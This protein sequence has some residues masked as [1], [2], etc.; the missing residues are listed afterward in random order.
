L[1]G[2]ILN[3]DGITKFGASTL[4]IN[5]DQSSL[6]RGNGYT[7]GWTVNEGGIVANVFGAFGDAVSTNTVTL[8]GSVAGAA[9]LTLN[10]NQGSALNEFYTMGNVLVTDNALI[11]HTPGAADRTQS[12]GTAGAFSNIIITSTGGALHDARFAYTSNQ[13]RSLLQ[14]GDVSAVGAN[15]SVILDVGQTAINN[16]LT[17][18]SGI[19]LSIAS[20]SGSADQTFKKWGNAELYIRGASTFAGTLSIEQGE[21][22]IFNVNSLG[23]G[24]VNVKRFGVLDI[25]AAGT[26]KTANYDIG[27]I[28]RWSVDGARTGSINLGSGTLQ[29]NNDQTGTVAVTMNG[30]SIEGFIKVDDQL[31]ATNGNQGA[32]YRILGA[33]VTF[34]LAGNSFLGQNITQGAN[35]FDNGAQANTYQPFGNAAAGAILEIKGVISGVG[36]LTKQGYDTVTL[37]GANTYSGGTNIVQGVLR[38]GRTNALPTSGNVTTTGNAVLDINGF[39]QTIRHLSSPVSTIAGS[40]G[41]VTNS[42]T[43]IKNLTVGNNSTAH[44]TYGGTIQ[45]NIAVVKTGGHVFR[46][47]APNTYVGGTNVNAGWLETANTTGSGTGTGTVSVNSGGTL[48]GGNAAGTT[49]MIGGLVVLNNGGSL[50]PGAVDTTGAPISQGGTL[51]VAALQ[52]NGGSITFQLAAP[53]NVNNDRIAVTG[54]D[55]G[56]SVLSITAPTS[57]L[58]Q[59][60]LPDTFNLGSYTLMTYNNGTRSGFSNLSLGTTTILNANGFFALS[61]IDDFANDRILLNAVASTATGLRWHQP[62][63]SDGIWDTGTHTPKNW[64]DPGA[65]AADWQQPGFD[66]IFD[67]TA[68]GT[69]PVVQG[70]VTPLSVQFMNS[71]KDYVISGTGN[72]AGSGTF[73]KTGSGKV[74]IN[75]GTNTFTGGST[76]NMGTVQFGASTTVVAGAIT[77]GPLGTGTIVLDPTGTLTLQADASDRTLANSV[78]VDGSGVV[79]FATNG[80]GKLIFSNQVAANNVTLAVDSEFNVAT[81]ASV[82]FQMPIVSAG[83]DLTKSGNGIMELA[84]ANAFDGSL[85]VADGELRTTAANALNSTTNVTVAPFTAGDTA[86]LNLNGFSNSVSS[87]T[88]G[89]AASSTAV[90]NTGAG[91]LNLT[92]SVTYDATNNAGSATI[93]GNVNLGAANRTFNVGDSSNAT[94]GELIVNAPIGSTGGGVVK[95]GAGVMVVTGANTYSGGTTVNNGTF[96]VNGSVSSAVT[97]SEAGGSLSGS[98]NAAVLAGNGTIN[99]NVTV[100]QA[101]GVGIVKPGTSGGADR[102]TLTVAGSMTVNNG[103]QVQLGITNPTLNDSAFFN[104]IKNGTTASASAWL[105]TDPN[106]AAN[107]AAWDVNP[108]NSANYDFI[109][110]TGTLTLGDSGTHV[111]GEGTVLVINEGYTA[112]LGD[113]FNLLDW[114]GALGGAFAT[115]GVFFDATSNQVSG[116]LDLPTLGTGLKWDVSAFASHG[117]LA[118]VPEPGRALLLMFGFAALLLRR[119]RNK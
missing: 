30:G 76:L 113:V 39:D 73:S 106:A 115:S 25:W 63:G 16:F 110:V 3:A 101:G 118:V 4:T 64:V 37:S 107:L 47:T 11:T 34:T 29:I 102:G 51:S 32:V 8:H 75:M 119:R 108:S 18:G 85:I 38:A 97:V 6:A 83:F 14:V 61:L 111:W 13:Q 87:L 104:A 103:S 33:G 89:G 41:Y 72:I 66:A 77:Q 10:A 91:T 49:G 98:Q 2:D 90:V 50:Q 86:T 88:L 44:F 12:L 68:I 74:T 94:A 92:G 112:Q 1:N 80:G 35:G 19:G 45:N 65:V 27:G 15:A 95:N 56:P 99:N 9:S 62:V 52:L 24:T 96:Q 46:V 116:D 26:T 31:R 93:N 48:A 84:N 114:A 7:K 67:D 79:N 58:I 43:E 59:E 55:Y 54:L 21:V 71:T 17:S 105:T 53:A 28:E 22:G 81:G 100:G 82:A 20:L 36:G 109:E 57:I 5:K 69:T 40:M 117:I 70:T 60:L 23:T 42:S 78:I